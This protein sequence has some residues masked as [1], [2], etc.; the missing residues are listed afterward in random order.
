M[1]IYIKGELEVCARFSF[2]TALSSFDCVASCF[3]CEREFH[4]GCLKRHGLEDLKVI[5]TWHT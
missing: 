5:T 3:Q 4:V 2:F 1:I